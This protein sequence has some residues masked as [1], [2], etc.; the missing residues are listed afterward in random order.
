MDASIA[1][2]VT[3]ESGT[4]LSG[5]SVQLGGGAHART[6][7]DARGTFVFSDLAAAVYT[8]SVT[9]G[10]YEPAGVDGIRVE[11]GAA[12]N[13]TIAMQAATLSSIRQIAHVMSAARGTFNSS[14][15]AQTVVRASQI[16]DA[17]DVQIEHVLDRTPG[18]ISARSGGTNAAVP[19]AIMSPNLRG[20]LD[21]EK[22][23]LL[24]GHPLI[25]GRFGDY[26]IMFVN[27]FLLDGIEIAQGPTANA[28]Q[29][30]YGIGGTVNFRTAES[31]RQT[32]GDLLVGTDG[33]GGGYSNVRYSGTSAN[34]KLGFVFDY[35]VYGTRGPLNGYNSQIALPP[36]TVVNGY[37]A[38]GG[39]ASGT[40]VNGASGRY[41]VPGARG[42]PPNAYVTLVACCESV[43]SSFL[44]RGELAKLRYAFSPATALTVSYLGLQSQYDNT[45]S[46]FTQLYSTFAPAAAYSAPAGGPQRGS[47]LLLNASTQIPPRTLLDSEPVLQAELRTAFH[48]DN[49]VARFYGA[50]LD[51]FTGNSVT[52]P[53]ANYTTAPVT[54]YGTAT[55][56]GAQTAF[57]GQRANLTI[58]APYFRQ[59]EIDQLRGESLEYDHPIGPNLL[60]FSFDRT[61]YL[62]NAYQVTGSKSKPG[63]NASTPIPAGSRQDFT[64]Y[65]TRGIWMLNPKLELTLANYFNVYQSRFSAAQN[66]DGS[67][68]F[69][70]ATRT[71]DDPRLGIAYHPVPDLSLRLTAGSAVAPPF[72]QLLDGL[73]QTP[74]Q[75][76]TPGATAVTIAQNSGGLLP[77]TSFGYD[78][79]AD[80]RLHNGAVLSFDA[81]LTNLRNQFVGTVTAAGTFTPPGSSQAIPVYVSANANLGNARFEGLQFSLAKDPAIGVGYTLS[82]ALQ[83][84]YPY[85]I[86]PAFYA[87]A[88]GPDTTNLGVIPGANYVGDNKPFFNGISNKSEAYAQG[89][90]QIDERW[91]HGQYL[92]LGLTYYGPNNTYNVPAFAVMNA[93]YRL[94]IAPQTTLQF[95]GDN[96]LGSYP[97][98]WITAGAGIPAPLVGGQTGLRNAVPMGPSALHIQ[99]ERRFGP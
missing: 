6:I 33:Y 35:A 26:P 92:A 28:A 10:G 90:A 75:V 77:E 16:K 88:A 53:Q 65:L 94:N 2:M 1:G 64:T 71:H 12:T 31:T 60:T 5:A 18:V 70:T 96:V 25:N 56:G 51:R 19:G 49:I 46:G 81:Y 67:F 73:S 17:G 95:S 9:K 22:E 83:R 47:Q 66:P 15:A 29:I 52:A 34:G 74:A 30:N 4:P 91:A 86:A 50:A 14:S 68:S 63:G 57:T 21:Y 36:G 99:L 97:D 27:A 23:T 87:T 89:F 42:N 98:P 58:P 7:T 11:S 44:N 76:Y 38:A 69:S 93:T 40:P 32:M 78:A 45:A 37:G 72:I 24:D 48:N 61:T 8:I 79:G 80:W 13:V 54:L 43:T 3:D 20:A 82:G 39:T 55:I 62:T 84:A 85:D 59:G 41:P